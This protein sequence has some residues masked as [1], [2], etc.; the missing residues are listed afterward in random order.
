MLTCDGIVTAFQSWIQ[1]TRRIPRFYR[2]FKGFFEALGA[3]NP[4]VASREVLYTQLM[5]AKTLGAVL[6]QSDLV[7]A[8]LKLQTPLTL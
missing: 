7:L 6:S 5:I 2:A 4:T 1:F 3:C 8:L